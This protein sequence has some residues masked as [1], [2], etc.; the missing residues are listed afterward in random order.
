MNDLETTKR[1]LS[2]R[3]LHMLRQSMKLILPGRPT[4]TSMDTMDQEQ[5]SPKL[6]AIQPWATRS[7]M[8]VHMSLR[9]LSERLKN[10]SKYP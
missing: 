4:L 8:T 6:P 10:S 3:E 1:S 5:F 9:R 7:L 2:R